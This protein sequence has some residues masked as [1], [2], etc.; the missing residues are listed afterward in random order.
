MIPSRHLPHHQQG[1]A[2]LEALLAAVLLAIGLLGTIGLQARAYSAL[3]DAGMRSEATIAAE[4]LIG[5][6]TTDAGHL[7]DYVLAAGGQPGERLAPWYSATRKNIP[8]ATVSVTVSAGSG[9][10]APSLVAITIGWQRKADAPA[11]R[12]AVRAWI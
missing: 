1:V 5:V 12:H 3:S 7:N 9:A 11:N 10:G 8:G 4:R 6:M 2:L